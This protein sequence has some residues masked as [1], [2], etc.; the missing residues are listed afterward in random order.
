MSR[1]LLP[2]D[3]RLEKLIRESF[4]HTPGPDMRRLEQ[5]ESR[6]SRMAASRPRSSLSTL[7]WWVVLLLAGGFATAAW[8]AGD[9]WLRS[10]NPVS[11]ADPVVSPAGDVTNR[12]GE[13]DGDANPQTGE[14]ASPPERDSSVIY[15]R[16]NF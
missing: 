14:A 5:L 7:P 1:F 10:S 6:L 3:D 16:E 15:Q 13:E 4:D 2:A 11:V 9:Q 8:W 12:D